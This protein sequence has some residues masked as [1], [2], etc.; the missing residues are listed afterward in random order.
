MSKTYL[1]TRHPGA[2]EWVRKQG[3]PVDVE[4][5]H[6]DVSVIQPGD[7]VIGILPTHLAYQV[8]AR[9]GKFYH[10]AVDLPPEAR[11]KEF[12]SIEMDRYGARLE[13]YHITI[14]TTHFPDG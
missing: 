10:I 8:C 9:G 5:P 6:L 11:G 1:I 13:P 14:P 2:V 7:V 3:L 4:L 12:N